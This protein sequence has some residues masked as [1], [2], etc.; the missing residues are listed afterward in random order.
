MVVPKL[1]PLPSWW[2]LINALGSKAVLLAPVGDDEALLVPTP[3]GFK[4][5]T[6]RHELWAFRV[7][8]F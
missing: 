4:V 5:E 3:H 6:L 2:P 7:D 1:S 8:R